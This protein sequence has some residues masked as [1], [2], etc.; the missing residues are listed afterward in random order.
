M[1]TVHYHDVREALACEVRCLE[2]WQSRQSDFGAP[3]W[4][5]DQ[6]A[7]QLMAAEADLEQ[8]DDLLGLELGDDGPLDMEDYDLED[9]CDIECA[10]A[11]NHSGSWDC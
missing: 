1:I 5:L 9:L 8:V 4:K 11:E 3:H 2:D 6:I 10:L 7:E